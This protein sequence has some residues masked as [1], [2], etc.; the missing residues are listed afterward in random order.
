[1]SH[2]SVTRRCIDTYN[3]ALLQA[4]AIVP[5]GI[6]EGPKQQKDLRRE[7]RRE[8]IEIRS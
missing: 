5:Q 7:T 3:F 4:S 1:M 2:T 6:I 8:P